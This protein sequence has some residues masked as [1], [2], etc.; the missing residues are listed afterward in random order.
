MEHASRISCR[1]ATR[2]SQAESLFPLFAISAR[3]VVNRLRDDVGTGRADSTA[4][5]ALVECITNG[6]IAQLTQA[7]LK[8]RILEREEKV[9]GRWI[10]LGLDLEA[11]AISGRKKTTA[12]RT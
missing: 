8:F 6:R 12:T 5:R 3:I 4:L 9:G 11:Q 2:T 10:V 7:D 1:A